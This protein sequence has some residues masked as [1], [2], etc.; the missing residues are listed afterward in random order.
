MTIA[1]KVN[2]AFLGS[3]LWAGQLAAQTGTISGR[4]AD[5]TTMGAVASASVVIEGTR[6]GTTTGADG[7]F[8]LTGVPVGTHSVTARFIGYAPLTQEVTVR[9]GQTTAVEFSLQRLSRMA[10]AGA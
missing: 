2:L 6:R 4:V 1:C 10:S 3:L 5:A 7:A 9:A 8:M